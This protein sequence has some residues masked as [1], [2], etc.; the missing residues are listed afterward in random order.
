MMATTELDKIPDTIL[1]RSQVFEFKTIGA[2]AIA[3]QLR[4][5]ADAERIDGRR[6]GA[7]C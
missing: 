1:S 7:A 4:T 2:K 5:I 3:E 6:R